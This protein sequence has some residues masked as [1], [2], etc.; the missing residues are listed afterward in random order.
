M[1]KADARFTI[2]A[3]DRTHAAFRSVKAG[4]SG[5]TRALGPV[6]LG[7]AGLVGTAGLG[8][9]VKSSLEVNDRL[10]KTAD[11]LGLT[12][13]ALAGM[14]HAAGITGVEVGTLH[15]GLQNMVRNIA[16]FGQGVGEAKREL[17]QLGFSAEDLMS[18]SPDQQF[19]AIAEAL[20]G[21]E[22]NTQRVNIAYK[23]FGGRATA[24]LNTLDLGADGIREL[25]AETEAFGTALDRTEISKIEQANDNL[26]RAGDAIKGIA[27]RITIELAPVIAGLSQR[28]AEATAAHNGFRDHVTSGMRV[29]VKAVGF[30][31]DVIRGLDLLWETAKVA[32]LTFKAGVLNGIVDL[33][34]GFN[35]VA[36]VIPFLDPAPLDG[37]SRSATEAGI[38]AGLAQAE[39][40]RLATEPLPS[41]KIDAFF[42]NLKA[43]AESAARVVA[44]ARAGRTAGVTGADTDPNP[45]LQRQL[46]N[47]VT[48]LATEEQKIRES[49]QRRQGIIQEALNSQLID[50]QRFIELSKA[51]DDRRVEALSK[52]ALKWADAWD[53]AFNRFAAGV[54]DAVADAIFQQ[55]SFSDAMR[56]VARGVIRQVISGLV[57]IGVKKLVLAGIE[58]TI[59]A[60]T[61]AANVAAG[62]STAVAWAPAAAAVSLATLG[63]NSVPAMAGMTSTF[64][65][66]ESLAAASLAGVAHDGLD[67]V[68]TDGTYLLQRGEG[69]LN[70]QDNRGLRD[71]LQNGGGNTQVTINISAMDGAD[72]ARVIHRQ[73]GQIVSIIRAANAENMGKQL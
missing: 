37:I 65:L 71:L 43:E 40:V 27:N 3:R 31:G 2:S 26:K 63:G 13:E 47:L 60:G 56:S 70:K 45:S 16:D 18:L 58:K 28:F 8:A 46:D 69:V 15:K 44:E 7:I 34:E 73:R 20:K 30:L 17:E 21:V 4:L 62:A 42:E 66:S 39:L 59:L 72:V 9:L 23:I 68:P 11:K 35:R 19:A 38:A 55:Q 41:D 52:N 50:Q 10:G 6:R 67:N 49:Y 54:G 64:A 25:S 51:N 29:V 33:A 1:G 36:D 61:T 53:D 12:T 24:L 22:N 5:L 14:E 57:E 48:S 32:F